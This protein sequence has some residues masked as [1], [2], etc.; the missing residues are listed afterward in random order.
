MR[1]HWLVAIGMACLA[2]GGVAGAEMVEGQVTT[3]RHP[4]LSVTGSAVVE[5]TPD[6]VRVTASII[7]E[8]P[9]VAEAREQNAQVANRAM[10]AIEGLKLRNAATKTV[11]YSMERVT[12]DADVSLKADLAKLDMPWKAA[13]TDMEYASFSIGLPMTLG[14]RAANSL[15]VRIQG[16]P[17]EELSEGAG[18]IIDA[19]MAAGCNQITSVAYSLEKDQ[20]TAQREALAKAV[21][22]AQMTAEVAASAAGRK[23]VGIRSIDPGYATRGEVLMSNVQAGWAMYANS[24]ER[25]PTALT[26]GM[27]EV[28]AQVQVIYDLDY[29][30]GDTEFLKAPAR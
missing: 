2:L 28:R 14:Y 26:V 18:K 12:R 21:K 10:S 15:T 29:N 8:G 13:V 9:T 17:R 24:E 25:T 1:I 30:P 19:L 11:G 20:S 22:D 3:V 7:T 6:T 5:V 16:V 4:T 23:I 27:L